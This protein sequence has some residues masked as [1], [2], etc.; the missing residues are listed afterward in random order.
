MLGEKLR[1]LRED[2]GL[3]QKQLGE[4]LNIGHKT[5]SDYERGVSSPDIITLKQ[6]ADYFQ[7]SMDLLVATE[8]DMKA[9]LFDY[10]F[11]SVVKQI[12]DE[13][14]NDEQ[15]QHLLSIIKG[16]VNGYFKK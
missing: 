6:F 1:E 2:K 14:L 11:A 7:V 5:I 4:I 15:K 9:K 10:Y 8:E 16:T 13:K 12:S 3:S